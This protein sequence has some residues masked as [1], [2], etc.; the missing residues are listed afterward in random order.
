MLAIDGV[1]KMSQANLFYQLQGGLLRMHKGVVHGAVEAKR[2]PAPAKMAGSE[3]EMGLR[4]GLFPALS[5]AFYFISSY[6]LSTS[7]I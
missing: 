7:L 1:T 2:V 3:I 5:A 6:L 4:V